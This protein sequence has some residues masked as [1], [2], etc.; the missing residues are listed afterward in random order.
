MN[1]EQKHVQK[2]GR[3]IVRAQR[4]LDRGDRIDAIDS[5]TFAIQYLRKSREATERRILRAKAGA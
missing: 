1:A 2:A 5:L 4:D 3:L